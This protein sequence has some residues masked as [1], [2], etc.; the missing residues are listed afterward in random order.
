MAIT[1]LKLI[2]SV[3]PLRDR[4]TSVSAPMEIA[5][6]RALQRAPSD[7]YRAMEQIIAALNMPAAAESMST[8]LTQRRLTRTPDA[9]G[10]LVFAMV[11][12]F[13]THE[14]VAA[15]TS[16]QSSVAVLPFDKFTFDSSQSY[17]A[18][19]LADERVTSRSTVDGKRF[20][21]RT[22]TAA[23]LQRG[24]AFED[25]AEQLDVETVLGGS[26]RLGRSSARCGDDYPTRISKT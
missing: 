14:R 10:V 18:E 2:E 20:A 4:R 6:T 21:P 13:A 9:S 1:T 15:P 26:V 22:S 19:G 5:L 7:R 8:V 25:I 12:W 17:F 3:A 11:A 23:L 24:L 16:Q